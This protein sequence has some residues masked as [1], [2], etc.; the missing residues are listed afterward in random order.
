MTLPELQTCLERLGVKLSLRLVVDAPAGVMT[1]EVKHALATHKPAL[2][3]MLAVGSPP[4]RPDWDRLSRERWGPAVGDSAPGI[5]IDR[6]A[7]G[8]TALVDDLKNGGFLRERT[9][10]TDGTPPMHGVLSVLSV[11]SGIDAQKSAPTLPPQ[12][13]RPDE[14]ADWPIPCRDTETSGAEARSVIAAGPTPLPEH[15]PRDFR[16]GHRWL[17]W[18]FNPDGSPK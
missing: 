8:L 12:P 18:H 1:P 16:L 4:V 3:A 13:P 2:L 15:G 14:L 6:P 9:D 11:P 5:V 10:N 17:P 7:R